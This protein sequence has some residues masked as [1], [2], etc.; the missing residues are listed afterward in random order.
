MPDDPNA[1]K[2]E[3]S[4]V[5]DRQPLRARRIAEAWLLLGWIAAA[6]VRERGVRSRECLLQG[7][8]GAGVHHRRAPGV[9]GRD[10]LLGVAP[11][12]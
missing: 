12:R 7:E 5:M 10:D 9:D 6:G 11:S 4:A 3:G 1:T 8:A 2:A